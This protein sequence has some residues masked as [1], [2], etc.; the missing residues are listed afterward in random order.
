V[1]EIGDALPILALALHR[2]VTRRRAP[3]GRITLKPAEARSFIET[4][5]EDAAKEALRS[6]EAERDDLRRLVIPRLA[7]WDRKAGS[8]GAAKRQ[9]ASAADLFAGP[10]AGLHK[11]AD[12][13]VTQRLLTRSGTAAG[14]AYEIAHEALLRVPPLGQLIYER[15]ERFEQASVLEI[16][17]REW[18]A[19]GRIA[20]RLGRA[21]DRLSEA[22]KLL[23]DEDFGPDLARKE[24]SV[25][26]YVAACSAHE[27]EQVDKQ[28]RIIGRAF[29]K[30]AMQAME[31][32]LHEHALRLAAAG[33][34]LARDPGFTLVPQLWSP[35][36]R[37]MFKSKIR[38]VLKG[39]A[40][41][42][43]VA[44]F[45]PDGRRIV[46]ASCDNTARV[47]D[48][49]SG[50]EIALL[51]A[52][53]DWVRSASFSRDGRRI[54]TASD[55]HTARVWDAESGTEIA[56]LRG[57]EN[58]LLSASFSPD[59]QRIVTAS[60]DNMARL[61]DVSRTEAIMR[62]RAIVLV[63]ALAHGIGW[64]TDKERTDLL[65]QDAEDDLRTEGLKQL[66]RASDDPEFD[67]ACFSPNGDNAGA[68]NFEWY[69]RAQGRFICNYR[70]S[71]QIS[72]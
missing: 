39:H 27:R 3:D 42:V 66:G 11:L 54:V 57:H 61:W 64:R 16:E 1:S 28:R 46:T 31:D 19:A 12:A 10:R 60:Y 44:S 36:A 48:A 20:G 41:A 45:S 29:V 63:A 33:A 67:R 8:D 2:M 47:W 30:P 65:M 13:L 35:A 59:G 18:N 56:G 21:G 53:E 51:K 24:A 26:D 55:D 6:V 62:E 17:A 4:A 50:K 32:G 52:H 72:V 69:F 14:A 25:A 34:L 71:V 5:V 40:G 68:W 22:E 58:W 23:A 43:N 49:E 15:R 38:A 37:A 70:V 7:T 9:V